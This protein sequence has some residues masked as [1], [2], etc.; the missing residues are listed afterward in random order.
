MDKK[1][2]KLLYRSLDT[3]LSEKEQRRLINAL[4]SSEELREEKALILAQRQAV[5]DSAPS[6][7]GPNFAERV[8]GRIESLRT[9]QKNGLELFY[10]TFKLTFRRM[11]IV[12]ALILLVLVSYNLIKNDILPQDEIIFASDSV[13]E[14]ILELPLF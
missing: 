10:E 6:S 11:A 4:E 9:K 8:M 3:T 2:L 1:S 14:E 12:S 13:V 5:T 7:F